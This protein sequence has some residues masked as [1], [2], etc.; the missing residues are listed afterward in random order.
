MTTED[1]F[2]RRAWL[3]EHVYDHPGISIKEIFN[4]WNH[5]YLSD[6]GYYSFKR[7]TFYEELFKIQKMFGVHIEYKMDYAG[8]GYYIVNKSSVCSY[9]LQRWML[10]IMR[11]T[12]TIARCMS[13]RD[14]FIIDNF[15]S[16]NGMLSPVAQAIE[17]NNKLMLKYRCYGRPPQEHLISPYCIKSY[18]QRLYV[19]GRFDSGRFCI[20]SLDR[21][22]EIEI[23]NETFVPD[24]HFDAEGFFNDYYGVFVS[25]EDELPTEIIIRA[26][27]DEKFYLQ[28]VPIHHSQRLICDGDEYADFAITIFPT[29]DFIGDILQQAGRL[30]II[31]PDSVRQKIASI[32]ANL[33]R[34]YS[35]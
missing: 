19:L 24:E 2:L 12:L 26:H 34:Q 9:K 21:I 22:D 11:T 30:E 8:A 16:E 35:E 15:P 31:S 17:N 13:L 4:D 20:F 5:S 1:I 32:T 23:I 25:S 29:N 14:K 7:S 28:S 27:G 10:G 3:I 33:C 18:K 6:Y